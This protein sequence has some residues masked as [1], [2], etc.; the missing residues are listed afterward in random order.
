MRFRPEAGRV[1]AENPTSERRE[2]PAGPAIDCLTAVNRFGY[3]L[4]RGL[5][6]AS[7]ACGFCRRDHHGH[8]RLRLRLTA[9][10]KSGKVLFIC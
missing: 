9:R 7:I 8:A 1:M 10:V 3:R 6:S 5:N 4:M 2:N